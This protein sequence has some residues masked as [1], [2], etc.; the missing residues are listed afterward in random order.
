MRK[1]ALLIFGLAIAV[2]PFQNCGSSGKNGLFGNTNA[3]TSSGGTLQSSQASSLQVNLLPN[4]TSASGGSSVTYTAYPSGGTP[5]YTFAW[6]DGACGNSSTCSI[7]FPSSGTLDVDVSVTDATGASVS[8]PILPINI[9]PVPLPQPILL[10]PPT[11]IA[12]PANANLPISYYVTGWGSVTC[13]VSIGS[14]PANVSLP[15]AC[16][17]YNYANLSATAFCNN[18]TWQVLDV[19]YSIYQAPLPP[20]Y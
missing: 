13:N 16:S 3:G 2:V 6:S 4:G 1:T 17:D 20:G 15:V 10:P 14:G 8:A 12:C 5:P 7:S 9:I 18:G 11:P 19:S